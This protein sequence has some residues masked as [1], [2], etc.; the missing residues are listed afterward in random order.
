MSFAVLPNG[1]HLTHDTIFE[2]QSKVQKNLASDFSLPVI[3]DANSVARVF[4]RMIDERREPYDKIIVRCVM[5]I[6]NEFRTNEKEKQRALKWERYYTDTGGIYDQH[7]RMGGDF[8]MKWS[9]SATT[10]NFYF[11]NSTIPS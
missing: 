7:A 9:P 4:Q 1:T 11:T 6:T 2:I 5:E 3:V 10:L 8:K